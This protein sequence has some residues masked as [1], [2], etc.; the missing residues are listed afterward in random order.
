MEKETKKHTRLCHTVSG[1]MN[2]LFHAFVL[3]LASD[4]FLSSSLLCLKDFDLCWSPKISALSSEPHSPLNLNIFD[5]EGG[6]RIAVTFKIVQSRHWEHTLMEL[7]LFSQK[8]FLAEQ[9]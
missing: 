8:F 7:T 4:A 5:E 1:R 9:A 6:I 3:P 2:K